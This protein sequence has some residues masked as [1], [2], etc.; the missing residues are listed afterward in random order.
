MSRPIITVFGATGAQGG[1]LVRALLSDP[2]RTFAIRAVTRRPDSPAALALAREGVEVVLADIDDVASCVRALE[3][4]HGAFLVTNFWEH[5]SASREL[6]QAYNLAAAS[7]QAGIRH[8]IWSTLEDTRDY[9]PADGSRM[10]VLQ[11]RY[12]VPHFDAKGEANRGF[13]QHRV[14]VTY[15]YTSCYWENLIHFGMGPQRLA[16]GSLGVTFPTGEARI[17][18]VGVADIGVVA[19]DIFRRGEEFVGQRIAVAGE[20]LSGAELAATL[21]DALGEPV[22]FHTI[23]PD[24]FRALGFPGADELGNMWQFKRDFE[25]RYCARRDLARV[26]ELHPGIADFATWLRANVSRLPIA[27]SA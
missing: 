10:P 21:G 8:A 9:V 22:R 2:N 5:L 27:R 11:E 3:G 6:T 23:T 25:A 24:E 14:P 17:P 7:A 26:R 13:A 18:W 1:G 19:L 20:H 4:A 12:N 15:L 16:D